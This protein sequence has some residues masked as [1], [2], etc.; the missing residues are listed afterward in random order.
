MRASVLRLLL[1]GGLMT[2]D[3]V[4]RHR[5]NQT[6][7]CDC[8]LGEPQTI[9]HIS[10]T[11]SHHTVERQPIHQLLPRIKKSKPC[12][13]YATLLTEADS[14]LAPHLI[15]I[16]TTLVNIWQ[17]HIRSYLMGDSASTPSDSSPG[18]SPAAPASH[19][20]SDGLHENGH[21]IVSVP[22]GG[23]YCRK[24]G[25]YVRE[26]K[27]RR[28]KISKVKC[29]QASLEPSKWLSKPGYATN[30][31]RLLGLFTDMTKFCKEHEL[32]WN[33]LVNQKDPVG[34]IR[35]LRCQKS[36]PWNNR[37]NMKR[38]DCPPADR[39]EIPHNWLSMG[40]VNKPEEAIAFLTTLHN[41]SSDEPLPSS[42]FSSEPLQSHASAVT[43]P[44]V[45]SEVVRYRIPQKSP[46]TA[47]YTPSSSSAG[48]ADL[49]CS[50]VTAPVHAN[51][52]QCADSSFFH[53]DDMG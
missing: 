23:I 5:T 1:T 47:L 28:L 42:S 44:A 18:P 12:F 38:A 15:L 26:V 7:L 53:F 2:Q 19:S 45:A 10:W 21:L 36:W 4:T 41:S 39:L 49:V 52:F 35:R 33:G 31:R 11:C 34:C 16:Q 40:P 48:P 50:G 22:N 14:D 25:K 30:P 29:E 32:I 6:T 27:H 17:D 37:H 8:E 24:C 20:V 3:V 13:Q 51:F 46:N 43:V 9:E